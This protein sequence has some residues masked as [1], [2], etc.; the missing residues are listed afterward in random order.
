MKD[1]KYEIF[2]SG[3]PQTKDEKLIC[4]L[5]PDL[6]EVCVAFIRLNQSKC[7]PNEMANIIRNSVLGFCADILLAIKKNIP[8]EDADF[9]LKDCQKV[10][11]RYIERMRNEHLD[12]C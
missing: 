1:G 5:I 7:D 8:R 3:N 4:E 2:N 12:K 11:G 10:F 9:F 6:K